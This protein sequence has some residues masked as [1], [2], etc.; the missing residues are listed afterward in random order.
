MNSIP[1]SR[2]ADSSAGCSGGGGGRRRSIVP[3][4]IQQVV[5]VAFVD[6]AYF[7]L[8]SLLYLAFQLI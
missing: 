7:I 8:S 4:R 6:F 2:A 3:P 5:V 1:E